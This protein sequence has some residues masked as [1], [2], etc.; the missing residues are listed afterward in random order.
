M[1]A[2][3]PPPAPPTP[4]GLV[5]PALAAGLAVLALAQLPAILAGAAWSDLRFLGALAAMFAAMLITLPPLDGMVRAALD[6]AWYRRY[7]AAAAAI[8]ALAAGF[9]TLV[10]AIEALSTVA[11]AL[12]RPGAVSPGI[13]LTAAAATLALYLAALACFA[14]YAWAAGMIA[15][16]LT[17]RPVEELRRH[18]LFRTAPPGSSWDADPTRQPSWR[19]ILRG[20]ATAPPLPPPPTRPIPPV[21]PMPPAPA[22]IPPAPAPTPVPVPPPVPTCPCPAT[23]AAPSDLQ[24]TTLIARHDVPPP[25]EDPAITARYDHIRHCPRCDAWWWAAVTERAHTTYDRDGL[26]ALSTSTVTSGTGLRCA[27]RGEAEALIPWYPELRAAAT[28]F[29]SLLPPGG[30]PA[31]ADLTARCCAAHAGL[32]A[33]AGRH[34]GAAALIDRDLLRWH[35]SDLVARAL[36][37]R[38][39]DLIKHLTAH[40]DDAP[41]AAELAALQ[42]RCAEARA[43]DAATVYDHIDISEYWTPDLAPLDALTYQLH[44]LRTAADPTPAGSRERQELARVRTAAADAWA[45]FHRNAR[46]GAPVVEYRAILKRLADLNP[47]YPAGEA[48]AWEEPGRLCQRARALMA[49]H[50]LRPDPDVVIND[51]MARLL[52]LPRTVPTSL[53]LR[54]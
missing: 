7:L 46:W 33:C 31:G 15:T 9:F 53:P 27:T 16:L 21:P 29:R 11:Y 12:R 19:D 44:A 3:P 50:R 38:A 54:P 51:W 30:T 4:A 10:F 42:T 48:D 32:L 22:N 20:R 23:T 41:A 14:G 18:P 49:A 5:V 1:P 37:P 43:A 52:G 25:W 36:R 24:H 34:P 26:E 8:L 13:S 39:Y 35:P 28:R 40:P 2:S 45:A 6:H 17:L 47:G